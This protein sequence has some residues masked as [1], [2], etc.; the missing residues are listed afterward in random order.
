MNSTYKLQ[1]VLLG[2]TSIIFLGC[3]HHTIKQIEPIKQKIMKKEASDNRPF[4]KDK[5]KE[6]IGKGDIDKLLVNSLNKKVYR[7][8]EELSFKVDTK[9]K[10]GYLY[11]FTTNDSGE[12]IVLYPNSVAPLSE[13]QGSYIF[14][15]DFVSRVSS[16]RFSVK[17][18]KECQDCVEEK[19]T[20]YTLLTKEPLNTR[21]AKLFTDSPSIQSDFAMT[22][23]DYFIK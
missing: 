23:V 5:L 7:N 20:I 18:E 3:T 4:L 11:V 1:L 14:P 2:V 8:K 16:E 22:K 19:S 6:F 12:I 21:G 10:S 13:I 15:N 17:M 9:N